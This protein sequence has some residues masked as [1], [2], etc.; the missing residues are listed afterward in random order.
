MEKDL[1]VNCL[2]ELVSALRP[3]LGQLGLV[4]LKG[5][6]CQCN[7]NL[8]RTNTFSAFACRHKQSG[9]SHSHDT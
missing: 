9:I 2:L 6:L 7:F 4:S 3:H 8:L 5:L 1:E